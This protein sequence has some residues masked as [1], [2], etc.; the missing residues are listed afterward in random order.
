MVAREADIRAL[1]ERRS[2]A[3][4]TKHIDQLLACYAPDVTYFD[5]GPPL[6]STGT[7]A[8]RERF[9]RWFSSYASPIDQDIRDLTVTASGD[10]AVASM[11]IRSGGTL[12]GGPAIEFSVRCTST[13]QRSGDTWLIAHEHVSVPVDLATRAAT[14]DL[15]SPPP[16][17]EEGDGR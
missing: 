12:A 13:F 5:V 10:L 9:L 8:L 16:A 7:S 15:D 17:G 2:G 6:Q 1:L 14:T 11:L 3:I 4:R